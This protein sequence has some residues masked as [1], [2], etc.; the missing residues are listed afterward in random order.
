MAAA[1]QQGRS[2]P[3]SAGNR[4]ARS[5]AFTLVELLVVVAIIGILVALL[6][7]AV[8][9]ARESARTVQCRNNL[10]QL[11]TAIAQ[12]NVKPPECGF[13]RFKGRVAPRPIVTVRADPPCVD[14]A[15]PS[16]VGERIPVG[17]RS[18]D[19]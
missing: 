19:R 4:P 9:S 5:A 14:G 8:N 10:K 12:C 7:P 18:A 2:A 17:R 15:Q 16:C 1:R 11:G 6:M 13:H 3:V